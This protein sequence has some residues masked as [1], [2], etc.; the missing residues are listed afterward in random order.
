[1]G[2]PDKERKG[3]KWKGE[4]M[5]VGMGG[6]FRMEADPDSEPNTRRGG[7]HINNVLCWKNSHNGHHREMKRGN[8]K[9]VPFLASLHVC[10]LAGASVYA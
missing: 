8:G 5:G 9:Q 3:K 2:I 10:V 1:M 6:G 4:R 7:M